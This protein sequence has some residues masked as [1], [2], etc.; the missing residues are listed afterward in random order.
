MASVIVHYQE[1]ALK[2]RN[3]PWFVASL[4]RSIRLALA[5]LDVIS[6]QSLM[7]RIEVKL[8]AAS[9]DEVRKRLSGLPGIGNFAAATHVA[10]DLEA[11]ADG[12]L[13]AI[14]NRPATPF[15]ISARRA[16]KRFP[17]SSPEIERLI[18][19][20]V[21]D[22]TGWPVDLSHPQLR[23]HVDVVTNDAFFYFERERGPGGLPIGTSGKVTCLLSGGI[24]SPVAAWR[25][26]K[27]GCRVSFVHFHSYP[28]LSRASQDKARALAELLTRHQLSSR[29]VLVS[30]A[31]VQQQIVLSVP[32]A[33]RVVIYRRMMVRIAER[34]A[35]RVGAQALVTGDVIGQVASQ[36]LENLT[37]VGEA[38]TLPMLRPLVG[39]DKEEITREAQQLG[40]Y[41]ISIIPDQDC[42][43]LF[44]P[45]F[46]A[47]RATRDAVERAEAAL[48]V[49]G[50][51]DAAVETAVKETF[52]F[53]G[54]KIDRLSK[55]GNTQGD[56]Q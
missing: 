40:T 33:L 50:L 30:F 43:T 39:F 28:V 52:R 15:R 8:G 35:R 53:P 51:V 14:A 34:L 32:P 24:D 12:V 4:V 48:D 7:G 5:D 20:R 9:W 44:T 42:C 45:R 6:V 13:K 36:T 17:L 46:P 49:Q 23:I 25:M 47:T 16:D 10:P 54:D 26:I 55:A 21:Q 18:G 56:R 38:A 29:L 3:R 2:G 19:R 27:R 1:L 37:V 31:P 11:I 41:E 22:A